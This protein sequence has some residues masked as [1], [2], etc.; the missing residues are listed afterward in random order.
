MLWFGR[1]WLGVIH[2][3]LG[4]YVLLPFL[5]PVLLAVGMVF[6]AKIIYFVYSFLCH[7]LPQRSFFLFGPQMTY[8]LAE[9]QSAWQVTNEP[10][11]LREFV[12]N[13]QMGWK[14]AWSDRMVAMFASL[15]LFGLLWG[16]LRRLIRRLPWWGLILLWLPMVSDGITHVISDASGIGL[17]FRDSNAWLAGLTA[18]SLPAAF[19]SGDA[20]GSFNSLMRLLTGALFG[21]GTVWY[22]YPFLE[23]AFAVTRRVMT[24]KYRSLDMPR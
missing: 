13:P 9:V 15:W 11:L 7:Q 10:W 2:I 4:L 3:L 18:N 1:H 16:G 12:G 5:A 8:S 24:I 19:Y 22:L 17:G 20:W 14:V 6:P 21:L 23:E